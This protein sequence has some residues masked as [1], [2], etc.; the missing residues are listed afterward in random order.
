MWQLRKMLCFSTHC[1]LYVFISAG[2]SS[3]LVVSVAALG[4]AGYGYIWWKVWNY[5][6]FCSFCDSFINLWLTVYFSVTSI[7]CFMKGRKLLLTYLITLN[8]YEQFY[9]FVNS[10]IIVIRNTDYC[11]LLSISGPFI[12]R[13]YVCD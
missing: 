8:F 10:K 7:C 1:F 4:V 9:P 13:Y 11:V 6:N 3:S 5:L 2:N 12:L